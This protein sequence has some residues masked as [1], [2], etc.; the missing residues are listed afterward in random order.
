MVRTS[1]ASGSVAVAV[2]VVGVPAAAL[3]EAGAERDG[4]TFEV[5]GAATPS[6]SNQSPAVSPG[7]ASTY[8]FGNW[9]ASQSVPKPVP[10][11]K[12]STGVE[13]PTW[14]LGAPD[15]TVTGIVP[16]FTSPGGV[17]VPAGRLR[18]NSVSWA[19]ARSVPSTV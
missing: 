16:S 1:P 12:G 17:T 8:V 2:I 6:V 18:L 11:P 10:N 13:V 19:S 9:P 15:T 4:A 7:E 5:V 14:M 3:A